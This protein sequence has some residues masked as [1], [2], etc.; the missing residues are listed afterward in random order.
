MPEY[1]YNVG[2]EGHPFL[3]C[4]SLRSAKDI[5]GRVPMLGEAH[6]HAVMVIKT[7]EPR[8]LLLFSSSRTDAPNLS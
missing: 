5:G 3:N 4:L 8:W 7:P 2:P 6:G 1:E